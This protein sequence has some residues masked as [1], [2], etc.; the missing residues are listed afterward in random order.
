[1]EKKTNDKRVAL[2]FSAIDPYLQV[3]TILPTEGDI[4]GQKFIQ[5]GERNLYPTFIYDTYQNSPT[6]KAIITSLV[7][8]T[9]GNGCKSNELVLSDEKLEDLVS[10]IA[11][12][13]AVYGG[14]ALNILRN[15]LGTIA[16]VVVLDLRN[17]RVN[18]DKSIFYYSEDYGVKSYGRGK[19]IEYPKFDPKDPR[20]SSSVFYYS[21]Q[22]W[23][24]Y[25]QPLWSASVNA[26]LIENKI[27][28]YHIN[29]LANGFSSNV[30]VCLN[31]GT[32]SIEVQD[33][34]EKNFN[35]RFC[36]SENSGRVIIAY[37][38]DRD[39]APSIEEIKTTDFADKYNTLYNWSRQQLFTAFRCNPQLVGIATESN[40]F[41]SEEYNESFKLFNRTVVRPLQKV[42]VNTFN[43][44][45]CKDDVINITPFSLEEDVEKAVE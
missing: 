16:D 15:R 12:S 20:Q 9:I 14:F 41:N 45:F 39:H 8:Y 37:S 3:N 17:L 10:A 13:F 5:W 24:T 7:D 6:L 22:R 32:P 33:E 11:Y 28:E 30:M 34:I 26:A 40:G 21:N 23:Q 44:I 31:N 1:M 43:K 4:N 42:I 25:P 38:A 2:S 18:K 19:Y 29:N 35:E 27:G 36:G